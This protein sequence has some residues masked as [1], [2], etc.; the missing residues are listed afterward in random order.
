MENAQK[1]NGGKILRHILRLFEAE[2]INVSEKRL[3][4]IRLSSNSEHQSRQEEEI[5]R[6]ELL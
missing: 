3:N 2:V 6:G 1:K 5:Q 4:E